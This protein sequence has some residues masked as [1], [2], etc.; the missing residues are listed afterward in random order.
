LDR[1][2]VHRNLSVGS[3]VEHAIRRGEASMVSNGAVT[4]TTGSHTG[5]SPKDNFII[6]VDLTA[7]KVNWGAVNQS[8]DPEKFEALYLRVTDY[9]RD[10]ELFKKDLSGGADPNNSLTCRQIDEN[11]G[12]NMF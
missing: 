8:F 11:A 5:R 2:N 1:P 3:L 7:T 10:K 6:K 9:P 12:H 4:A